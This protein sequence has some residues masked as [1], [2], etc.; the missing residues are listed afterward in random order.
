MGTLADEAIMSGLDVLGIILEAFN[1]PHLAHNNLGE[2][3][4]MGTI[5]ERKARMAE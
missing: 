4:V 3:Q 5:H 2:M 1:T